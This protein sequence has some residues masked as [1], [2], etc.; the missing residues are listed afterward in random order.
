LL[1]RF[2]GRGLDCD[3]EIVVV[4]DRFWEGDGP[5]GGNVGRKVIGIGVMK[6]DAFDGGFLRLSGLNWGYL[7]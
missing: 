5:R 4:R 3:Y 7:G 2:V 6:L 1:Q